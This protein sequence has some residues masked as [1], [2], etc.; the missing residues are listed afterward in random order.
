[1]FKSDIVSSKARQTRLWRI[2]LENGSELSI[3]S[4]SFISYDEAFCKQAGQ[5]YPRYHSVKKR[6]KAKRLESF[7]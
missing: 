2:R 4:K 1:M 6:M 5:K 7:E 3:A